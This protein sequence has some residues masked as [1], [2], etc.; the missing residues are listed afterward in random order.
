MAN[1]FAIRDFCDGDLDAIVELSLRA[2]APVF[3]SL[4]DVPGDPIFFRLKPDWKTAQAEEVTTAA[5]ATSE[6][7]SSLSRS[8]MD[9]L[10]ASSP[11]R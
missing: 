1:E 7:R 9:G 6:T 10:S 8:R 2:W 4:R 3:A 5:R 11:S